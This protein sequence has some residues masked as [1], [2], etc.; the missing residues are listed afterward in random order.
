VLTVPQEHCVNQSPRLVP[1]FGNI[2][3]TLYNEDI[4]DE[5]DIRAW[6]KSSRARGV[7]SGNEDTRASM[8][9]LRRVGTAMIE[10]FEESDSE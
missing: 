10:R 1:I 8:E 4:V 6:H 7:G 9:R 3:A 2:L 5:D